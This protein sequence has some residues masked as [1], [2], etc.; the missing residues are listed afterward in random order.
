MAWLIIGGV[1]LLAIAPIFM[2]LPSKRDRRLAALRLR[3]RQLGLGV[4]LAQ[5]PHPAPT[6]AQQ[7]SAGGV[8]RDAVL[9]CAVYRLPLRRPVDPAD[10]PVGPAD[11]P[12]GHGTWRLQ[13]KGDARRPDLPEG[14]VWHPVDAAAQARPGVIALLAGLGPEILAI[15]GSRGGVAAYWTEAAGDGQLENLLAVLET[16][17]DTQRTGPVSDQQ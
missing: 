13:R 3:A 5:L 10:S 17:R 14:W 12:V 8:A 4:Q 7:V 6:P 2:A 9:A 16:L 15:E 11:S 1:L